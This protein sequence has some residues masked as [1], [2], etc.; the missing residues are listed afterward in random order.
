ML[1]D[2]FD[3]PLKIK[4]VDKSGEFSGYGSVFGV[5]DSYGDVVVPGAFESSLK[6]K[7]PAMLWQHD[8]SEPIGIYTKVIEDDKGLYVEGRLLIDDDPLAKR[9]HA[10][11]VAGS[12]SGLSI[13]YRNVDWEYDST[14]EVFKIKEVDL[15]EISLVTFPANDEARIDAVKRA[16]MQEQTP[17]PKTVERCLRD[18][19]FSRQQAKTFMSKGY[20]AIGQRD[21]DGDAEFLEKLKSTPLFK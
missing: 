17:A 13:G 9:A 10:H 18:A 2:R 21:A 5:E 15:W 6:S 16:M 1:K 20:S 8:T 14:L 12:L 4:A 3:M 7:M 11:L 19:G